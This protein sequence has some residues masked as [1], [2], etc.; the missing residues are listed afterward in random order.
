MDVLLA[1]SAEGSRVNFLPAGHDLEHL[2]KGFY[3]DEERQLLPALMNLDAA[4]LRL[5]LWFC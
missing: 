1:I 4:L 2:R 3:S 5:G